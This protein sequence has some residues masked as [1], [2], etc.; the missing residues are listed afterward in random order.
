MPTL[1]PA[2]EATAAALAEHPHGGH[3]QV[4][5]PF[6][7]RYEGALANPRLS[8]NLTT[9]QQAWRVARGERVAEGPFD[10]LRDG[11]KTVKT[12]VIDRLDDHLACFEEAAERA[13]ATVHRAADAEEANRIVPDLA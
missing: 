6:D 8:S 2:A 12:G 9:F 11:L 5:R 4:P 7:E 13:G 10:E 1:P 3:G